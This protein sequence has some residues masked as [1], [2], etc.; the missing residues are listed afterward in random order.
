M[1]GGDG[2]K[3]VRRTGR[4]LRRNILMGFVCAL[5]TE[6]VF[7]TASSEAINKKIKA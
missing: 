3:G 2:D 4:S 1:R 5:R 7:Q 6:I